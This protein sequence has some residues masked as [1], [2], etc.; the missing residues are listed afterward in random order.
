MVLS[1]TFTWK[2]PRQATLALATAIVCSTAGAVT[3][4]PIELQTFLGQNLVAEIELLNVSAQEFSTLKANIA[5]P[6]NYIGMGMEYNALVADAQVELLSRP[7]GNRFIRLRTLRPIN[8]PF[9]DLV[10][11]VSA[12]TAK[13]IRPY[14]LLLD[15]PRTPDSNT[16]DAPAAVPI[17]E[18]AVT[19]AVVSPGVESTVLPAAEVPKAPAPKP[20]EEI[21]EAPRPK[22]A[23]ERIEVKRG[24]TAAKLAL[25][26]KPQDV[27][28]EQ[29]LYGLLQ[30]NPHAF[31]D[32]N[33]NRIRAGERL[34]IPLPS[35]TR[36]IV[37][38]QAT[39]AL[40]GQ[41]HSGSSKQIA[42]ARLGSPNVQSAGV[43]PTDP[44]KLSSSNPG[45][46]TDALKLTKNTKTNSPENENLEQ[47]AKQKTQSADAARAQ[48]LSKNIKE[49][50][51]L[52]TASAKSSADPLSPKKDGISQMEVPHA[53]ASAS[54]KAAIPTGTASNAVTLQDTPADPSTLDHLFDIFSQ[55]GTELI[56]ALAI[57]GS[58]M[59][60]LL[61]LRKRK[62]AEPANLPSAQTSA[63]APWAQESDMKEIPGAADQIDTSLSLPKPLVENSG[64]SAE[65][66]PVAEAD[67]YLAYG[68]DEPA[69][70]ILREGLAQ[71]P[72]RVQ[73]HLKLAEIYAKRGDAAN[74]D[75]FAREVEAISGAQSPQ[76]A[77]VQEWGHRL[78]PSNPRYGK[79]EGLSPGTD[80]AT[81]AMVFEDS[82]FQ[83][84]EAFS[85]APA[86]ATDHVGAGYARSA[87]ADDA[88]L[89]FANGGAREAGAS[90]S[91][92]KSFGEFDLNTLSLDLS[93]PQGPL[94][95]SYAEQLETSMELAKQFIEIGEFQGARRM[96]DEVLDHGSDELR[97]QAQALM[98]KLK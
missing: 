30:A 47:I 92:D 75:V 78:D 31:V 36:A 21:M 33:V 29:M 77:Q 17:L 38:A 81:P 57:L 53:P 11:E 41:Y 83:G 1:R 4:A 58:A 7:N 15:P 40:S 48:E 97:A 94:T 76:W 28:I 35:A 45:V 67:V 6:N 46:G 42:D 25:Q 59:G 80:K 64:F 54:P 3:L 63:S 66:D 69:L 22:A 9:V 70:E 87:A 72:R 37:Q 39:K 44:P 32:G 86:Q 19:S 34:D 91:P 23:E 12:G 51:D 65:L 56:G 98:A 16:P 96:L 79:A 5:S 13:I 24:D 8:D 90:E 85:T 82:L 43:M 71:D 89:S 18:P 84:N 49:L 74:F 60:A 95:S 73:I 2:R 50:T 26:F 62:L 14:R 27:S 88:M 55:Y 52:A 61:W 68:K 93:T 20:V 10:L